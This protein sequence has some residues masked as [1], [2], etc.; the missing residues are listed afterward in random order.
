MSRAI[1][2]VHNIDH[3]RAAAAAAAEQGLPILI[4]SADG[5]AAYAGA[6]WFFHLVDIVRTE[7]PTA[8]LAASLDCADAPGLAL[9]ALRQGLKMIRYRGSRRTAQK[10]AAIATQYGATMDRQ[11]GRALDLME[12]DDPLSACRERL[13]RRRNRDHVPPSNEG[14]KLLP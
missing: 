14:A 6:G 12:E 3:A 10:V 13:R 11:R 5:A 9:A 2:I 8:D 4:R 7:Y 1:F